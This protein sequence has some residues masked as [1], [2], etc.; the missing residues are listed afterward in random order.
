MTAALESKNRTEIYLQVQ[1]TPAIRAA[2][3]VASQETQSY[4]LQEVLNLN[5]DRLTPMPNLPPWVM[6]LLNQR[7]RIFWVVDLAEFLG[8]TALDREEQNQACAIMQAQRRALGFGV[9]KIGGILRLSSEQIQPPA[10]VFSPHLKPYLHGC[11]PVKNEL[12]LILDP[13]TLV[14]N[15]CQGIGVLGDRGVRG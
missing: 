10:D 9:Q 3:P 15:I 14:H 13:F 11:L 6:G 8:F 4:Q 7:S 12:L 5:F 1:L 2:I